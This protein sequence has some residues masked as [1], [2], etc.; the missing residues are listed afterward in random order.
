M[1]EVPCA[2]LVES[3]VNWLRQR[4]SV[5]DI[6]GVCEITTPFLDRHND[7]IQ[8]YV[9]RTDE[10]LRLTD[11][12][13]TLADLEASGVDLS[14][15]TQRRELLASV[16]Q[17]F[18]VQVDDREL[19]VRAT[20]EDFPRRKHSLVQAIL[21]VNDL[22]VLAPHR[23]VSVFEEDVERYLR[24]RDVRFTRSIKL[25]GRSGLDHHFQLVVPPS[26]ARPERLVQAVARL[27]RSQAI[28]LIFAWT[29]VREG[30]EAPE[31]YVFLN[32][33]ERIRA[34]LVSALRSYKIRPILWS[35]REQHVAD[36]AA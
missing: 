9:E 1:C 4:I 13:Y 5:A 18:G 3:Y 2:Q 11:D 7:H 32:D 24:D 33:T 16:T 25:P 26:R 36:L 27:E 28:S 35:E 17:S 15:T 23:V 19:A 20:P 10:G 22:F 29:D 6:E 14:S 30:R 8:I 21:A 31:M 12:G 34:D